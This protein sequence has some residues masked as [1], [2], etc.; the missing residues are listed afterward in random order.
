MQDCTQA[1]GE[2]TW[3]QRQ[4]LQRGTLPLSGQRGTLAH[5][6]DTRNEKGEFLVTRRLGQE[7]PC[8]PM[9]FPGWRDVA[10]DPACLSVLD[11]LTLAVPMPNTR[12]IAVAWLSHKGFRLNLAKCSVFTTGMRARRPSHRG[13]SVG[14]QNVRWSCKRFA[15]ITEL[16]DEGTAQHD[17]HNFPTYQARST[18]I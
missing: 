11:D 15:K 7:D 6:T 17:V 14:K 9:A 16:S 1:F 4:A 5:A 13:G 10:R 2:Q 18:G 12:D 3:E 8:S